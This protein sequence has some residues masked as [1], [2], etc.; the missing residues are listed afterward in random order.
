MNVPPVPEYESMQMARGDYY[1][2]SYRVL[3]ANPRRDVE[4]DRAETV[5]PV[6]EYEAMQ[7]TSGDDYESSY[8]VLNRI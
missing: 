6:P 1:E 5:P 3:N 7:I 4:T 8:Q 2:S